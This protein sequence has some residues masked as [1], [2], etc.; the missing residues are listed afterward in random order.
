MNLQRGEPIRVVQK[1]VPQDILSI[2]IKHISFNGVYSTGD[3]GVS[4][5][6]EALHII[7]DAP[8]VLQFLREHDIRVLFTDY[9]IGAAV[10]GQSNSH[11]SGSINDMTLREALDYVLKTFPGIWV[12]ENYP[13][14]HGRNR[15]VFF[16]FFYLRNIGSGTFV[17]G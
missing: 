11:I 14:T 2:R 6:N 12:Y 1:G 8:E 13:K 16:R 15:V 17:E 10:T 9:G 5:P 4:S 3:F 7:L